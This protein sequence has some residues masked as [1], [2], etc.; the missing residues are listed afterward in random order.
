[1]SR[2]DQPAPPPRTHL[3]RAARRALRP[4]AAL[5]L[6]AALAACGEGEGPVDVDVD[7]SGLGEQVEQLADDARGTAEDVREDLAGAEV[8]EE[9]RQRTETAVTEAEQAVAD[10]QARLE[11]LQEGAAPAPEDLAEAERALTDARENLE[12]VAQ[13]AEGSVREGLERLSGEIDGLIDRVGE[14]SS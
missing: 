11:Q 13:D 7:W 1:M 2:H 5:A 10:A 6:A 9:V 14:A 3:G 12:S 4:A 8:D